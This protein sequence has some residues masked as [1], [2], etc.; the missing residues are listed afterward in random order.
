MTP[1]HCIRAAIPGASDEL[2][3]HIVWGRTPFPFAKLGARD[4]YKAASSWRRA[5][6]KGIQLCDHCHNIASADAWTCQQCWDALHPCEHS[7]HERQ[8][9]GA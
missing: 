1:A 7:S 3:D 9:D 4:F 8:G 2:V 6:A 5:A